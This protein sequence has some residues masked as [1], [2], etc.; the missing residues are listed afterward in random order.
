MKPIIDS[1]VKR[2]RSSVAGVL[3]AFV[4]SWEVH[5]S[6]E[7][8]VAS[9]ALDVLRAFLG[10]RP[11]CAWK[12]TGG[13]LQKIAERDV[14]ET[15][16]LGENDSHKEALN[17]ALVSAAPEFDVCNISSL[18]SD[19]EENFDGFL[20]LPI[21]TQDEVL[22]ILTIAAKKRES[23]DR[24][25]VEPMECMARLIAIAWE[26][27]VR[28]DSTK[29]RETL[30]RSEVQATTRELE[31]TNKRLIDRVRELKILSAELEER[32][33]ELTHANKAKDE[34]LSIVSHELRTPL[35]SLNGFLAVVLD[36]ESGT[37]NEEQRKF[38][39][40]AKQGAD[41]LNA[42]I[43]DLLDI[44]RIEGGRMNLVMATCSIQDILKKSVEKM[45]VAAD[46]KKIN[47][48]FQSAAELPTVWADANRIQQVV[49]NLVAN[50]IKFTDNQGQVTVISEERGDLV[51]VS[52]Q[53]TG[54]GLA[55]ED[56]KR[57]F[58]MFYQVDASA[59]RKAGGAGLGLSIAYGIISLHGGQ[60]WVESE[61]G[62]GST[63][64]FVLPRSKERKAA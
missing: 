43:G 59:R 61:L 49:D 24:D 40:I 30:L 16:F 36:G 8:S 11:G 22:G 45:N 6:D 48:V 18:T 38:L 34:F 19:L 41:R 23:R 35:T 33:K 37:I 47:I 32:V 25:F 46:S 57:V 62:N 64:K 58:D 39:T 3:L 9:G 20:H 52:V 2:H 4:Q 29:S 42:L 54:P 50:A 1:L 12:R 7:T 15:F 21:R 56:Q 5:G 63:F 28:L 31:H 13:S 60:L 17:R 53:D 27:S 44:S 10:K 51:Q 26:D 55:P 14:V